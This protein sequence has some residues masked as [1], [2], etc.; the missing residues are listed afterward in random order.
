MMDGRS[1][2]SA[3]NEN[4][5]LAYQV[6]ASLESHSDETGACPVVGASSNRG[7]FGHNYLTGSPCRDLALP[8]KLASAVWFREAREAG[9]SGAKAGLA[10]FVEKISPLEDYLGSH[11]TDQLDLAKLEGGPTRRAAVLASVEDYPHLANRIA[12]G[13]HKGHQGGLAAAKVTASVI[14][15]V[16]AGSAATILLVLAEKIADMP[17]RLILSTGMSVFCSVVAVCGFLDF[18]LSR[19]K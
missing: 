8:S 15:P 9:P 13:P 4:E 12:V 19:T 6:S 17:A 5:R 3:D 2:V 18:C 7:T 14:M 16:I 11:K 10:G 1:S